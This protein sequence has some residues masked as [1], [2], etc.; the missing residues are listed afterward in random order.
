MIS[1]EFNTET[2]SVFLGGRREA[3]HKFWKRIALESSPSRAKAVSSLDSLVE[4]ALLIVTDA[5]G[6]VSMAEAEYGIPAPGDR[7]VAWHG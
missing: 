2:E 6:V 4:D 3:G 1:F 5:Q 7:T